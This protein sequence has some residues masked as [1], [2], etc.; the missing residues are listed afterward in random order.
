MRTDGLRLACCR[1]MMAGLALGAALALTARAETPL[2]AENGRLLLTETALQAALARS[3]GRPLPVTMPA[4]G[5]AAVLGPGQKDAAAQ[6]LRRLHARGQAAGHWGD[7]Y[8]NRDRDHSTLDPADYPQLTFLDYGPALQARRVDYGPAGRLILDRPV[9]GNSSTAVT[10]RV[11]WR[12]QARLLLTAPGGANTL[13]RAYRAGQIHV[14]PEHRDHDPE[15]GDLIPANTPYFVVSQGS[16]SSD[17]AHL[18]VLLMILAALRPET[19]ALLHEQGLLA[20]TIQMI[21]RRS[22]TPVVSRAAYLSGLAH[23]S[24]FD[25][26]T[27]NAARAVSL[28]NAIL[29]GDVPPV[30]ALEVLEESRPLPGAAEERLFDTPAAI[31]RVWR[32]DA[33]RREMLVSAEGT[34]DPAGRALTFDWVLLRGDPDRVRITP[35]EG[36]AR[37]RIVLDW[38]AARPVPGAEAV[39]SPRIDIGVFAHNGV[40]DSAPSFVSVLMPRHEGRQY[41][42]DPDGAPRL[43]ARKSAPGIYA[44]PVIFPDAKRD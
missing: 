31:A 16:S 24:V 13:W 23:P 38:Q 27:L 9:I 20:P 26:R 36:G 2:T 30:V 28:A 42:T 18:R 44:D 34:R 43:V 19:K 25:G 11:L 17:R 5:A 29:P 1:R 32:S 39:L 15:H 6:L 40:H 21:Y 8:D 7:L 41:E 10:D 4:R 12:S 14:Y 35:L 37:A 22:R 33:G 3:A